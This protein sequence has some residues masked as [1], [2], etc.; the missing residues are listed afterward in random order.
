M[1]KPKSKYRG[2][3]WCEESQR[4]CTVVTVRGK[5]VIYGYFVNERHAADTYNQVVK[6]DGL[7]LKLNENV[8]R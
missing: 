2:V 3:F 1:I 5:P 8:W 4:W 6:R 7:N